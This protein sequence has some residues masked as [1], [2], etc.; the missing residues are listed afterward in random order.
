LRRIVVADPTEYSYNKA[1]DQQCFNECTHIS[2]TF[3][4]RD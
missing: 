4:F 2:P 1:T 3:R